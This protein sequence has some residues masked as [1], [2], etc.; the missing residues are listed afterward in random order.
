M[1]DPATQ[2]QPSKNA[3]FS[4]ALKGFRGALIAVSVISGVINLLALTGSFYMLQVYD[5]VLSSHSVPTL[6]ALSVLA[7]LLFIF[8]GILDVLRSQSSGRAAALFD[9]RVATAVHKLVV[10][11]PLLG[12]SRARAQQPIR[13]VDTI[14]TF[15]ASGGPIAFLDL[16]WMPLYLAF[17]F[18]LHPVLGLTCL[19]GM[20]LLVSLA[21]LVERL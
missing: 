13:D 5:R 1:R 12:I 21:Y 3:E 2:P 16:P 18:L 8:Q 19:G 17:V 20:T 14:R 9:R 6:V 10:R 11:Q 15:L 7:A 4:A